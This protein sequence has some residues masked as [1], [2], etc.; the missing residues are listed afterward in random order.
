[1]GDLRIAVIGCGGIANREPVADGAG[2]LS[3]DYGGRLLC[4]QRCDLC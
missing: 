1:M 2:V 3:V 4:R